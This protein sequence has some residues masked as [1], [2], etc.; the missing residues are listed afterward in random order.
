ML[1]AE[2]FIDLFGTNT[3]HITD[4]EGELVVLFPI[5]S[6]LSLI[7]SCLARLYAEG[8]LELRISRN[9]LICFKL[10]TMGNV[11]MTGKD[12]ELHFPT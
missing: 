8:I 12:H 11:I 7:A 5:K 4:M 2:N 1:L 3:A 9:I 10:A 6:C